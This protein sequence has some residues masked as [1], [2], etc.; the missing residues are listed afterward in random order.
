MESTGVDW[1]GQE[2][3]GRDW[4]MWVRVY[5]N[6]GFVVTAQDIPL[7]AAGNYILEKCGDQVYEGALAV[8][9]FLNLVHANQVI[10][11]SDRVLLVH[12]VL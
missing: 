11:L 2:W 1:E 6:S 3:L 9:D 10:P 7:S 8:E 4:T 12:V 5:F